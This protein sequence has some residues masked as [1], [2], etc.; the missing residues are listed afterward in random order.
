MLPLSVKVTWIYR[1]VSSFECHLTLSIVRTLRTYLEACL[2]VSIFDDGFPRLV[3][4]ENCQGHNK[5]NFNGLLHV[6]ITKPL[7][8]VQN[9]PI[10]EVHLTNSN[11]CGICLCTL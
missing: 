2:F 4:E 6:D 10:F 8:F 11:C 1:A 9:A 3:E 5:N 7:K